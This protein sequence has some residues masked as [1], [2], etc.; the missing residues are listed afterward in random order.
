VVLCGVVLCGV[1]WC[2]VMLCGVV[3]SCVVLRGVAWCGIAW[4]GIAWCGAYAL[5]LLCCV[6]RAGGKSFLIIYI[7]ALGCGSSLW[8]G[9]LWMV[10]CGWLFVWFYV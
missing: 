4:C 8:D 7:F 5:A 1:V 6:I 10:L 3:W 9:F 2:C